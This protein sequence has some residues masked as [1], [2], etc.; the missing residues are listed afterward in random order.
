LF[1]TVLA[2][3]ALGVV[4]V[5]SASAIV[6]GERFHDPYFFL[7]RQL[8][9]ALLGFIGLWGALMTDYRKW[10]A[11]GFP[12]LL[13]S[14]FLLLLVLVPPFGQEINGT[15]RWLR[16]GAISFQPV[17]LAKFAFVLYLAGF[18][19][20]RRELLGNFWL[21]FFPPLILAALSAGLVILQPDLGNSL[22]IMVIV[23]S[24][25]FVGGAQLKQMGLVALAATPLLIVAVMTASYR[26][27]RIWA[28]W[29]PWAD[30]K[31]AG[32]QIIQ[33][34][35]AI[36]SGGLFG[37]G[38]GESKQKLFY[39]PEAHTDFIFSIVGEEFGLLG[40]L[41]V[42]GL[43]ICFVWR[44]LRIGLRAPDAFGTFLALGLT[45]MLTAQI[46]INLGVAVGLLPTKGL[47]LPFIS[48]GGSALLVAMCSAGILLNI[49]QHGR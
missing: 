25:L 17:E 46:L 33:S 29:D 11:A 19:D 27:K 12:L 13:F 26:L 4:M 35:L 40:S 22:T 45:L 8:F 15:R 38:L 30:P 43:F 24:L 5:Y 7:K 6:A 44:G 37:L 20:R 28:F 10:R 3:V 18:L 16:W 48:F 31:G 9:W 2:L 42:I 36:G 41:A 47:P 1:A 49:S 39:L 14:L 34:Y 21:G 32:F 23:F